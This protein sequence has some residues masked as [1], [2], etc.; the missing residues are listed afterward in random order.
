MK[1][2]RKIEIS[3]DI[4]QLFQRQKYEEKVFELMELSSIVFPNHYYRVTEQSHGECDY[5][6]EAG[7]K[8]DAKL[9]FSSKQMKL[10]TSGKKHS[11]KILEWL[12]E[13]AEEKDTFSEKIVEDIETHIKKSLL[14]MIMKETIEANSV[15]ENIIFFF[16]FPMGNDYGKSIFL[17][18]SMDYI[19]AIYNCL[20]EDV[21]LENRIVF[22]IYPGDE[23]NSFVLKNLNSWEKEVVFYEGLNEY[24]KYDD[25]KLIPNKK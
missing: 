21:P 13:Q 14:Y 18:F 17:Q 11:P 9:P 3:N 12:K 20:I 10:L 2:E 25:S 15:D 19:D 16:P 1:F 4:I 8:Y 6:D 22:A 23:A 7:N 24:I 5:I